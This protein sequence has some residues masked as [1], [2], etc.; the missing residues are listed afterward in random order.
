MSL[1][2]ETTVKTVKAPSSVHRTK[3]V[4]HS[5]KS[6]TLKIW[7]TGWVRGSLLPL[8]L[9]AIWQYA[10]SAGWIPGTLLPSPY[11]I[12]VQGY[13]L[14][15]TGELLRHLGISVARAA[16]GFLV[17]GSIGLAAGLAVGFLRPAEQALDPMLQM[18]RTIP[19]LAITPLFILWFGIGETSKILLIALGAFFPLYV[20]T[21]LG[22][23]GVDRKLVEVARVL[24]FSRWQQI[25]LVI[26]PGALPN[27]LL[28]VR[29]SLGVSW[30]GLV[31]AEMMGSSSG[32]GYLIQDAR[33]FSVITIVFV[34]IAIFAAVGKLSD[35]LVRWLEKR[36][37]KWRENFTG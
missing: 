13:E 23:R 19:H 11:A 15:I 25:R 27:V 14:L 3:A 22:I 9:I 7:Q 10:S 34:G 8:F 16:S 21:F 26:L 28:G 32:V 24:E 6:F 33:Q 12:A 35:S 5:I 20:N 1:I 30:L 4:R 31:V 2:K 36:L 29:L 37:L 17:G 18:L